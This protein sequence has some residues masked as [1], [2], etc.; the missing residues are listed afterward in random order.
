[1]ALSSKHL[2]VI[3]LDLELKPP[4]TLM[5][6]SRPN[7]GG[8]TGPACFP[9]DAQIGPAPSA[10][11]GTLSPRSMDPNYHREYNMQ[12]SVGVQHEIR[13][14]LMLNFNW[15]HRADYQQ[16]LTLNQAVPSS[17]WTPVTI[18]NPLDGSPITLYNLSKAYAGLTPQIYQTN[19]PRSLRANSYNG[20]E[21]SVQ[22][23]LRHGA[24]IFAGWTIDRELSRQC[25]ETTGANSLNDPNSLRY[26]DWYGNL[27]QG[28]GAVGLIPYR[29]EFKLQGNLPLWYKFEFSAS[30]YSDPV[31][32]TNFALNNITSGFPIFPNTEPIFAGAQQGFKEVYWTLTSSTK[33]PANCNCSTP[34][35][36]VDPGLA[37][38]S[39][40]IMLVAPGSRL[41]PQLTQLDI[42]IRRGFVIRDRYHVK[43][44]AQIF[45]VLNSNAVT[46]EAQTLGSS[47]TPFVNGGIGGV[48]TAIL[49]PRMLR[50]AVQFRF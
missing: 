3:H 49:N 14:G 7:T 30:L 27:D 50:L 45:N 12:Y 20:L 2:R 44:E 6:I 13:N 39:E 10:G 29:S 21:T 11:F 38:G 37:Q 24:F 46:A 35:A 47:V 22:G 8:C 4:K 32:N 9:T 36:I 48:P 41:T 1:L 40:T 23:R 25:D 17:A 5:I 26:C 34:G 33:Y 15:V 16:A 43:A 19:A 18:S 31:Y 42:A 28:L